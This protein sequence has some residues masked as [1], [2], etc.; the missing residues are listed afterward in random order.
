LLNARTSRPETTSL[1]NNSFKLKWVNPQSTVFIKPDLT[2]MQLQEM[3]NL[4]KEMERRIQNGENIMIKNNK[5][6][7]K[8]GR[9]SGIY[10]HNSQ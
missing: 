9:F 8:S 6:V 1:L 5:I 4:K 10:R 7:S 3:L 2:P